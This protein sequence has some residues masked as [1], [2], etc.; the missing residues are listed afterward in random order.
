[1]LI[2]SALIVWFSLGQQHEAGAQRETSTPIPM[3]YLVSREAARVKKAM[4]SQG[5]DLNKPGAFDKLPLSAESAR[6]LRYYLVLSEL[7]KP[8]YLLDTAVILNGRGMKRAIAKVGEPFWKFGEIRVKGIASETI[9]FTVE[10]SLGEWLVAPGLFNK[11]GFAA[12]KI[13]IVLKWRANG[14]DEQAPIESDD[15]FALSGS[16][17]AGRAYLFEPQPLRAY[18]F[19]VVE[20]R[21]YHYNRSRERFLTRTAESVDWTPTKSPKTAPPAPFGP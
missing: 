7:G 5:I 17:P 13:A 10:P 3:S 2:S 12:C 8:K 18:W 11:R 21:Y 16:L 19:D 14:K 4:E 1:M 20:Q 9:E 6:E 15:Y